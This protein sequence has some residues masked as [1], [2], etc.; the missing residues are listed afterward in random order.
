M[1][2]YTKVRPKRDPETERMTF[3]ILHYALLTAERAVK[4]MKQKIK[5]KE[6]DEMMRLLEGTTVSGQV[7]PATPDGKQC[8][9]QLRWGEGYFLIWSIRGFA[10]GQG[11]VFLLCPNRVC[12]NLTR[13]CP[14][15]G[16]V[17]PLSILLYHQIPHTGLRCTEPLKLK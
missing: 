15:Q 16:M 4:I 3:D 17:A 13:V 9:I 8:D 12:N 5:N 14:K 10:A 11:I 7:A 1:A 6:E 2:N